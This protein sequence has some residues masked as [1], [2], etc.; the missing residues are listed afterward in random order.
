MTSV[1]TTDAQEQNMSEILA[2]SKVLDRFDS[3][4]SRAQI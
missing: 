1:P 3:P 2:E 4:Q